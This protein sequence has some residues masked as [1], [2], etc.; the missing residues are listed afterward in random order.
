[1]PIRSLNF[2][3]TQNIDYS[4]NE[5]GADLISYRLDIPTGTQFWFV[6]KY[7]PIHYVPR[8]K[9]KRRKRDNTAIMAPPMMTALSLQE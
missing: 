8:F 2:H 3:L 1:V 5:K 6:E 9:E 7:F 4:S